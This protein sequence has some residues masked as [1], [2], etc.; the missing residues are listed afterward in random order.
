MSNTT[1]RVTRLQRW[2]ADADARAELARALPRAICRWCGGVAKAG[3]GTRADAPFSGIGVNVTGTPVFVPPKP[4]PADSDEW[5]RAC[6]TC[7]AST[8]GDL[9]GAMIGEEV[10]D[11]EAHAVAGQMFWRDAN[12]FEHDEVPWAF[13]VGRRTGHPFQHI[14]AE[15]RKRV[16]GV[17]RDVRESQLP[18][19]CEW[20]A[21]GWCGVRT[22]VGCHEGPSSM[23]W[24]DGK[25]A[26][27]CDTCHAVWERKASPDD[28]DQQRIAGVIAATGSTDYVWSTAP[29]QFRLYFE[30][31]TA[32][33]NGHPL[34]WDYGDGIR[35]F[36]T[37]VWTEQPHLAPAELRDE[38]R[39]RHDEMQSERDEAVRAKQE[40]ALLT[41]W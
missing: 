38:Y 4:S 31:R 12:G 7:A 40:A 5:R 24:Q 13:V 26:P 37:E 39:A 30:T 29:E 10:T 14:T 23:V 22:S 1:D 34:A 2:T 16:R 8:M 41:V 21:C 32:D 3:E 36:R 27:L 11:N 20:G 15:D 28:I 25:R 9:L 6:G 35:A 18:A 33:G 19:L 17:L